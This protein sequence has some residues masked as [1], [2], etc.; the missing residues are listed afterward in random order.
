MEFEANQSDEGDFCIS[1]PIHSATLLG[2]PEL[3]A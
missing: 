3:D 1:S 2:A